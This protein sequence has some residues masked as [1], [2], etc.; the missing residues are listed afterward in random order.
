MYDCYW[1]AFHALFNYYGLCSGTESLDSSDDSGC[2]EW[3]SG[4]LFFDD[5]TS[6]EEWCPDSSS[7]STDDTD[8]DDDDILEGAAFQTASSVSWICV[9]IINALLLGIIAALEL[10]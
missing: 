3:S 1:S 6:M 2:V 9:S 8:S 4:T 5:D 7:A 10:H